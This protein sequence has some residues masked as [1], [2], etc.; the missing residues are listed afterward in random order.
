MS[1]LSSEYLPTT[2]IAFCAIENRRMRLQE[3]G[4]DRAVRRLLRAAG[5]WT[6]AVRATRRSAAKVGESPRSN[7]PCQPTSWSE[8]APRPFLTYRVGTGRFARRRCQQVPSHGST[9]NLE[10]LTWTAPDLTLCVPGGRDVLPCLILPPHPPPLLNVHHPGPST[11][12][13]TAR[14]AKLTRPGMPCGRTLSIAAVIVR[15]V[16]WAAE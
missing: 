9:P 8:Q 13:P 5:P 10:R 2:G 11:A 6:T 14:A 3:L 12:H 16:L 15:D 4:Q 7:S 1:T